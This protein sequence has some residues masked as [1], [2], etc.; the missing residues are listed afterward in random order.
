MLDASGI[1]KSERDG[2]VQQ[3]VR[4]L[5]F[6]EN[7]VKGDLPQKPALPT[8]ED[9]PKWRR[10]LAEKIKE[11]KQQRLLEESGSF[12][13]PPIAHRPRAHTNVDEEKPSATAR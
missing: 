2:H 12:V 11:K 10:Q 5:E 4:I 3:L 6:Q 8:T 1:S 7:Y 13:S 9:E